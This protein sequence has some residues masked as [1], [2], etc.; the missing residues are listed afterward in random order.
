[1]LKVM[2]NSFILYRT[3]KDVLK[4]ATVFVLFL[5]DFLQPDSEGISCPDTTRRRESGKGRETD[6]TKLPRHNDKTVAC[7]VK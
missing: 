5:D 7:L 6:W 1:M 2:V 4:Q 3:A